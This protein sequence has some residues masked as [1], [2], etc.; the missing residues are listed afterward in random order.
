MLRGICDN[1]PRTGAAVRVRKTRNV[2]NDKSPRWSVLRGANSGFRSAHLLAFLFGSELFDFFHERIDD[3]G[4]GNFANDFALFEDETDTL[5][6]RYPEI[7]S[8][9]FTGSVHFATH[10]GNVDIEIGVR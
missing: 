8:A 9:R 5:A 2:E 7:R 3:A 1:E 4:F 6:A 10:H